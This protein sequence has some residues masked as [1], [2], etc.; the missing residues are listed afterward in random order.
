MAKGASRSGDSLAP[1]SHLEISNTQEAFGFP[2][3]DYRF[4]GNSSAS[5]PIRGKQI[6][7]DTYDEILKW[8]SQTCT[9]SSFFSAFRTTAFP[10]RQTLSYFVDYYIEY[11]QPVLPF[12]HP[13]TFDLT[14]SHWLLTL[15][16][17]ATGSH[18]A[19][20][21]NVDV[22]VVPMQ[23]FLRR[24][25]QTMVRLNQCSKNQAHILVT[26]ADGKQHKS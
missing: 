4:Q 26:D 16:F 9:A 23:E 7:Q 25:I 17:A 20:I 6:S 1:I 12:T 22:Y 11:F 24:V 21:E 19:D 13:A 2:E 18:Y 8:F 3:R 14:S 5:S 10:S 15:A